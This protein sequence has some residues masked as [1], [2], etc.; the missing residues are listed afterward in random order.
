MS[1]AECMSHVCGCNEWQGNGI[2]SAQ[3][4]HDGNQINLLLAPI[5][6]VSCDKFVLFCSMLVA[7][8]QL[9]EVFELA[10]YRHAN[11]H[12][13]ITPIPLFMAP[14]IMLLFFSMF[15]LGGA[16]MAGILL[17][18]ADPGGN[19]GYFGLLFAVLCAP[20]GWA[21]HIMRQNLHQKQVLL[22]NL[23]LYKLSDSLC[24]MDFDRLYVH[25]AITTW[26]L[27]LL[28]KIVDFEWP[29]TSRKEYLVPSHW[30]VS[31][32]S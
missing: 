12:G 1:A 29:A 15:A 14:V 20:V 8:L 24:R 11:P 7:L 32:N 4:M 31:N 9:S 6:S 3:K 30:E 28:G 22:Q 18:T 5:K 10:A 27:G 2:Y 25:R 21:A 17:G 13:K 26:H 19:P 16:V 23:Q